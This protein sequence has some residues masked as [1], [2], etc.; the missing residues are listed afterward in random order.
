MLTANTGLLADDFAVPLPGGVKAVWDPRDAYRESTSHRERICI[1][2]LWR[3]QPAEAEVSRPPE[4]SWGY[5]KVPGCWPGGGGD[6][7]RDSQTLHAHPRWK[8]AGLAGLSAAW[9][10]R[11]IIV[12]DTWAGRRIALDIEYLNSYAAVFVDGKRVG[13]IRFPGGELDLAGAC[14]PGRKHVLS[15]LVMA[16]PLKGVMLSYSDTASARL[17]KGTVP[18]RGL[19]GDLYLVGTPPAARIADVRVDTS[20]RRG[21]ISF[22][23]ALDGLAV[24]GRYHLRARIT[25]D[26]HDVVEFTSPTFAGDGRFTFTGSWKPDRLWD[27]HTPRNMDSLSLSL[28]DAEGRLL[29]AALDVRF[30]FREFRID[31]RDFYLNGSRVFLSAVPLDN[32]QVDASLASYQGARESLERLK[33]FGINFVYT[34]NYDCEPGSHLGFAEVLRAADDVGM[35]VA[36]TQPHFSHYDWKAADADAANGYRRHAE[37]YARV[38]GNHPSV[39]FYAMSHN[40]TGYDE[41]MNPDMIDGIHDPREPWALNNT[42]LALRAEAIVR[43]LDPSRIVYHHASG[44]LGSMHAINFYPNFVPIQELSDWFEHWATE[45]VKPL[46][47]CEYGAPFTWDWSMYRGWYK[48]ERSFGS[49]RVPWEFCFAEWNAQF[50]G[51]RAFRIG[52]MERANLRWEAKKFRAGDLWHRWDYP[53]EIGS[54]VF[55]DRHEVIGRYLTDNARAFRTWGVSATSPWEYGHFWKPRD[56]VDRGRKGLS[57]DWDH[58]QRPGFS[59]DYFDRPYER[60]DLA[61]GRSDWI[62]TAD[63]QALLRNNRPLLAYIGGPGARFTSKDHNVRPGEAI[64]KQIII[65]NNS[66]EAVQGDCEWS[67]AAADQPMRALLAGSGAIAVDTGQQARVPIR[68]A[69]PAALPPGRYDL[70]ATVKFSTGETQRDSVTIDVLPPAPAPLKTDTRIA[71]FDPKGETAALLKSLGI[72]CERIDIDADLSSYDLLVVGKA[73]LAVDGPAP[74]ID[75][76]RDGLKV[77][78]FEQTAAVLEE[79]LGFRVAEYGLRQV[80]PRVRDHPML[81]GMDAEHLRDWRGESTTLP[82]RLAYELRPRYGPT[83]RWSGIPV[84]RVWRCGNRGTVASVLIEKPAR[85]DFLPILDGGFSLQY[86]PLLEYRE[87]RGLVVF[88]Q[89]DLSGRTESDPAADDLARNVLRYAATWKPAPGRDVVYAGDPAGVAH[90]EAAGISARLHEGDKLSPD[91]VLVIGPGGG[92]Q[93]AARAAEIADW[94]KAGG[95]VLAIGLDEAEAAAFVPGRVRMKEAEHI[96]AFFEPF[97]ANS[98]FAGVGPADVHNRDPRKLPLVTGG[99]ELVGDGVLARAGGVVFCQLVPWQ[100]DYGAKLNVKRTYRRASFLVSRLL[101]N[102]GVHAGT[103]L[104]ARFGAPATTPPGHRRRDGFYLDQPEEGD[105]PYRFFRW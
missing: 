6:M 96:A 97:A 50:L 89:L 32:A 70:G 18:R 27:L 71:L 33:S 22:D 102:R 92:R 9:Y 31:G 58:L 74:R 103:P 63:G 67:I 52:E 56:G 104:L 16:L 30:G 69:L 13:E 7:Q 8:D 46:F 68:F 49:A 80:F 78:V 57:V 48:G 5:F 3:W 77:I 84:P 40:A 34:H 81:S 105:D 88:C 61:F 87:G 53:Y 60:I 24:G 99:A 25:R 59:P 45:G 85:G 35:L 83:V 100:F 15:V 29:D 73:A 95:N 94:L 21:Q 39:V 54:R 82:P 93:L 47:T 76:V 43:G 1:N 51:D 44:N 26:G 64:E 37:F 90:L 101:A 11:E 10:E 23:S 42:K 75:R 41:D 91:R 86:S 38:A 79:R 17:V 20:V 28:H 2:G 4:R 55:D 14:R 98:P 62:A 12:P 65:I 19:C 72:A 36:L 66:R